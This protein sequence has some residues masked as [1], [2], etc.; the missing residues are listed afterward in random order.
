MP[1]ADGAET[2]GNVVVAFIAGGGV[3]GSVVWAWHLFHLARHRAKIVFLAG[4]DGPLPSTTPVAVVFAARDEAG[5]VEVAVR[6]MLAEGEHDPALR[7]VA[8]DDRSVDGTGAILDRVAA[9]HPQLAVIHVADLPPG[10][11][12]KTHALQAGA[13]SPAAADA[14]WLL[15]TDADVVFAPGSIRRA[16]SYAEAE[17]IDLLSV[18]PEVEMYTVGERAFLSLFGLL[19][20]LYASVGRLADRDSRAHVGIGAFNLVRVEAFN[21][22]GGFRHLALSVDDDM[23]LGQTLKFAGYATRLIF[24]RGAIS[25]RWHDGTW[26]MV[27]GV[28]KNFFAGLKFRVGRVGIV[29]LGLVV[30][31]I[32]P[33]VGLFVGPAWTR[34]V[35]AMGVAAIAITLGASGR[36]SRIRWYYAGLFPIATLLVITAL[37]RSTVVT[38]RLGGIEW[39]RHFY[40]LRLLKAHV[41]ERDAWLGE[42]WWSCR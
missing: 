26:A 23:R 8:V 4:L 27:R 16:M 32:G 5:G 25:V 7:V 36:Q 39:R 11:L 13:A 35:A 33:F 38:L 20:S 2:A 30:L 9:D 12:G 31:G 40:P 3:L 41:R 28:E 21:A 34:G 15:L 10:W 18:A 22:V 37:I 19:F 6:S 42:V 17:G 29:A 1:W 24:G 14:G